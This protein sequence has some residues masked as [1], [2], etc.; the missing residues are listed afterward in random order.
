MIN[1]LLV[2]D[3]APIQEM[4]SF[5]LSVRGIDVKCVSD[6]ASAI[7]ELENNSFSCVIVDWMLPD[8]SGTSLVKKIRQDSSL[9]KL[10][11][12]ML[13]AKADEKNKLKGFEVG[14]DDYITK[15]FSPK[16][17]HA[18]ILALLNRSDMLRES[19]Q[20]NNVININDL[21]IDLNTCEVKVK[22]NIVSLGPTEYKLLVYLVKN[23]NK[24]CS[25]DKLLQNVWSDKPTLTNRTVDVHIR[26]VRSALEN[27]EYADYI[28]TLRSFGYCFKVKS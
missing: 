11:I 17:L 7:N 6:V 9:K 27:T 26:R 1:V 21:S 8:K 15:P 4:V 5:T 24:V 12:I 23:K 16:E 28:Q 13:T 10:P 20:D 14:V 22:N 25:R 2:E 18:R 19:N 3:E